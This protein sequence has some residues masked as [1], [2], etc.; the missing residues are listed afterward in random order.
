[1][2]SEF[3]DTMLSCLSFSSCA[4]AGLFG[5][6][7]PMLW[8]IDGIEPCSA[9]FNKKSVRGRTKLERCAACRHL[10]S[11]MVGSAWSGDTSN[12]S[13]DWAAGVLR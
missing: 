9:K 2:M 3:A 4:S 1:L 11:A 6:L 5:T 8:I 13:P 10:W 12:K 7:A